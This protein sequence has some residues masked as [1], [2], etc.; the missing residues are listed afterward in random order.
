M[1]HSSNGKFSQQQ[2][3]TPS[4][5]MTVGAKLTGTWAVHALCTLLS[6]QPARTE[7]PPGRAVGISGFLSFRQHLPSTVC[8]RKPILSCLPGPRPAAVQEPAFAAHG[9]TTQSG[10]RLLS[11]P[12][13]WHFPGAHGASA[14]IF[15]M[16]PQPRGGSGRKENTGEQREGRAERYHAISADG[17]RRLQPGAAVLTRHVSFLFGGRE[18]EEHVMETDRVEGARDGDKQK[19]VC[20]VPI[21]GSFCFMRLTC[22]RLVAALDIHGLLFSDFV[23]HVTQSMR[24]SLGERARSPH[25]RGARPSCAPLEWACP[26]LG[27]RDRVCPSHVRRE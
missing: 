24:T 22:A 8:V 7:P 2:H 4:R 17:E 13:Y 12:G 20:F 27:H 5:V 3:E 10:A 16:R 26:V 11:G 15:P 21:Q 18:A 6:L 1:T 9:A 23:V 19:E 25:C 14:P